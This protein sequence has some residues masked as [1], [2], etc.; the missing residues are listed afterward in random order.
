MSCAYDKSQ[1][2]FIQA[3]SYISSYTGVIATKQG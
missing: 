3:L 1:Q 2:P